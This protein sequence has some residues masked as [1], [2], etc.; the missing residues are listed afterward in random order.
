MPSD[1]RLIL[2]GEAPGPWNMGVDEALLA[3]AIRSGRPTLRLYRWSGP[4]LSL[5]YAQALDSALVAACAGAGVGVVRRCTGGRAV[6]HGRDLTYAIAAPEALLP[7]GLRATY[8]RIG[9]ALR[10][11][12]AS[13]GI[14]ARSSPVLPPAPGPERFDC[15]AQLAGDEVCVGGRKLIGSAQ[16]REGGGVLQHGSLRLAPDPPE[17]SAIVGLDGEKATSLEEIGS[18]RSLDALADALSAAF[19]RVLEAA[20]EPGA[21]TECELREARARGP[22]PDRIHRTT[23]GFPRRGP[24]RAHLASR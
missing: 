15:F 14:S 19:S 22:E 5:G 8:A 24:S 16:R 9:A 23:N 2:D 18:P 3:S 13:L 10:S 11:A 7:P 1:W 4:W 12:L 20:L 21:P 17:L 6:L